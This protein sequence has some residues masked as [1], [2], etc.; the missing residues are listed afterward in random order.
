MDNKTYSLTPFDSLKVKKESTLGQLKATLS[1]GY[2]IPEAFI[3]LWAF[4]CRQN[5]TIRPDTLIIEGNETQS[6]LNSFFFF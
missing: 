2:Q 6:K 3:R 1:E 5:K 4:S